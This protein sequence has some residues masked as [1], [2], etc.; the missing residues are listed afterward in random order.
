[1]IDR[2]S[3]RGLIHRLLTCKEQD[4]LPTL[5]RKVIQQVDEDIEKDIEAVTQAL[6]EGKHMF[7]DLKSKT[8]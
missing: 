3:R 5:L 4:D 7:E 1:M 2:V 6:H 8:G